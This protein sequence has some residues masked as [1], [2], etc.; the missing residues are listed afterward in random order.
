MV[1]VSIAEEEVPERIGAS[2]VTGVAGFY[3]ELLP[4]ENYP[5]LGYNFGRVRH[6]IIFIVAVISLLSN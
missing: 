1:D 3:S 6:N 2:V 5:H 4:I